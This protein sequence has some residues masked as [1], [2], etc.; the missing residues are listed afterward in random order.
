[1]KKFVTLFTASY[2]EL[3]SVRTITVAA[4][5]AAIAIILG[6]FSINVGN[7][8]RIGFSS[9]PNGMIAW[10]FG[11]VTGGVFAGCLDVLK[12]LLKPTGT[13]FPGFTLVTVLAGMI[14]GC[15]YYK[16]PI[17]LKR[18]LTAKFLVMLIC[19]VLLNTHCLSLLY[20]KSFLVLLP[21]RAVKNLV[22]WPIDSMIFFTMTKALDAIGLFRTIGH[23]R[24]AGIK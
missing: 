13:F 11:P 24:T 10:L 7:F 19:N 17:T 4:M 1:M 16:R 23:V 15:M 20:G 3:K 6:M 22:M 8:I 5:F 18:V 14:Y 9:I 2:R 21:A 12:Y